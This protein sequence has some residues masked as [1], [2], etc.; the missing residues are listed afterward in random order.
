MLSYIE[1]TDKVLAVNFQF[2]ANDYSTRP[3]K[4]ADQSWH[5][6][7]SSKA[8][9]LVAWSLSSLEHSERMLYFKPNHHSEG[10]KKRKKS[11]TYL[12]FLLI[13]LST[14]G[15]LTMEKS[16]HA[17]HLP[18]C[19]TG[20]YYVFSISELTTL[21]CIQCSKKDYCFF[22]VFYWKNPEGVSPGLVCSIKL[23]VSWQFYYLTK[24][25]LKLNL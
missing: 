25:S 7:H 21:T 11:I 22:S 23:P 3:E 12:H 9:G 2:G 24:S 17:G 13:M 8:P 18:F 6:L 1:I 5:L 20:G 19:L 10:K 14:L 4:Y 15:V 16:I